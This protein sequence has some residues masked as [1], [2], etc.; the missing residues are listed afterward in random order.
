MKRILFVCMGNSIRSQMAEGFG[1]SYAEGE[2]LFESAGLYPTG[3]VHI[4]AIEAMGEIGI[5]IA[6]NE[7]QG[8]YELDLNEYDGI[9]SLC[10]VSADRFCPEDFEGFLQTWE[11]PDPSGGDIEHFREVRDIIQ[12]QVQYLLDELCK[13]TL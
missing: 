12:E 1:N 6:D 7:S 13:S 8:I 4:D 9:I 2:L 10:H 11:I 3:Y 5:N